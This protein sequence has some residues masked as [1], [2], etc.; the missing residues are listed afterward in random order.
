[1]TRIKKFYEAR[2]EINNDS[3]REI[4]SQVNDV[5]EKTGGMRD[6]IQNLYKLLDKYT[7]ESEESDDA[8]SLAPTETTAATTNS[9][10]TNDLLSSSSVTLLV[11]GDDSNT[12]YDD[13][14]VSFTSVPSIDTGSSNVEFTSVAFDELD[15]HSATQ[16]EVIPLTQIITSASPQRPLNSNTASSL[17]D[18]EF[19]SVALKEQSKYSD[20][21]SLG[22]S[23]YSNLSSFSWD[24]MGD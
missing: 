13:N 3:I 11:S 20:Q 14:A 4:L 15:S 24:G 19:P 10:S 21:G 17:N 1:M 23:G 7:S 2:E 6:T 5:I 9:S 22:S 18:V 8:L 16:E 12:S